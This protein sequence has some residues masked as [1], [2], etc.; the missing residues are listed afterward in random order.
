MAA[1]TWVPIDQW[2]RDHSEFARVVDLTDPRYRP[3]NPR[4]PE[5]T[6]CPRCGAE[7]RRAVS[8][9]DVEGTLMVLETFKQC[10]A[11]CPGDLV[12]RRL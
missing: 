2:F 5:P 11:G 10:A 8:Y 12:V 1:G 4:P 7:L 3:V 6:A 9:V